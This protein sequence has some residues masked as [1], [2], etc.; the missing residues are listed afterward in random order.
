MTGG[1]PP[2]VSKHLRVEPRDQVE[3]PVSTMTAVAEP[4]VVVE[5]VGGQAI[6]AHQVVG[7]DDLA[8]EPCARDAATDWYFANGTTVR[9]AQQFIVLFNPF[10]DDAIVD[11][12]FLTDTGVLEPDQTQGVVVPRR[13]RVSVPVHQAVERQ[14]LI[15]A[16]VH[17][18]AGRVVAERSQFFDGSVSDG[19]PV[20]KGIA[21]SLGSVSPGRSWEF[22]F[23]DGENG[24][25]QSVAIA[26]FGDRP[27]SVEVS[28]R[29]ADE[30][31]IV[32]KRVNVARAG[33]RH[34][35]HCG[36][37]A[38]RRVVHRERARARH[39]GPHCSDRRRGAHV[40]A[41]DGRHAQRCHVA[42]HDAY[43]APLGDR[44]AR[45]AARHH[46]GREGGESRVPSP[47]PRRSS[48][49]ARAT[50]ARRPASPSWRFRRPS[51]GRS[52]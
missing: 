39:R 26:N 4:G 31:T 1:D 50:P 21:L 3:V 10:G 2:S 51:S 9:G 49:C 41:A 38:D 42:R 35:R 29:L 12:S 52:T 22:A 8:V 37:R 23:G 30:E 36:A 5:V 18:R 45:P 20:R 11:I 27:T 33:R 13:S 7:Q 43:R 17:A 44:V 16:H 25:A 32:P 19:V 47:S 46:R 28:V 48:R 40:V 14:T 34:C 6:V 24:V 15:A